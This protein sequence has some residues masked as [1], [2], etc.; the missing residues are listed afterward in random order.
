MSE[1]I[2]K[3]RSKYILF[4]KIVI[5]TSKD[6]YRVQLKGWKKLF[7]VNRSLKRAAGTTLIQ[8]KYWAS[9]EVCFFPKDGSSS[10]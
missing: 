2:K 6:T 1:W 4:T 3:K 8:T 9:Q 7:H 5:F 10:A